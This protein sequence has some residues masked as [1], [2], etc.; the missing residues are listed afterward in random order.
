MRTYNPPHKAHDDAKLASMMAMLRQG[1]DL[2]PIVVNGETALSGSHRIAAYQ[3]AQK[4]RESLDLAWEDV[5]DRIPAVE[6][7]DAD[8][9]AAA[10]YLGVEYLTDARDCNEVARAIHVTTTDPAVRAAIA[11]QVV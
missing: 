11:D 1:I 10:D 6:L 3:A 2:P 9:Q 7:S 8:C 5:P 4:R